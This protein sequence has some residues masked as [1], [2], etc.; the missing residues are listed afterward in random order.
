MP[1]SYTGRLTPQD[2]SRFVAFDPYAIS[3]SGNPSHP[4]KYRLRNI[5]PSWLGG[6]KQ[7][8]NNSYAVAPRYSTPITTEGRKPGHLIIF[9][10]RKQFP[11]AR[12]LLRAPHGGKRNA[13]F[14]WNLPER[15]LYAYPLFPLPRCESLR[16]FVWSL[17]SRRSLC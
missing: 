12:I 1:T 17:K 6:K 14:T 5:L 10:V 3:S 16:M 2:L 13:S 9:T 7:P 11:P 8:R 15:W 4:R